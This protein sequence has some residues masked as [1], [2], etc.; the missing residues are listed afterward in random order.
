M[1]D[2]IKIFKIILFNPVY[3]IIVSAYNNIKNEYRKTL[4]LFKKK[5]FFLFINNIQAIRAVTGIKKGRTTLLFKVGIISLIQ[6]SGQFAL[7]IFSNIHRESFN[8]D[9]S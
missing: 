2:K 5:F 7:K 3:R 1:G 4:I 9:V 8:V 6:F